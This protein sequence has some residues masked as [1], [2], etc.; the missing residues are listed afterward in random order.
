MVK[1][2][3][4][5]PKPS[6]SRAESYFCRNFISSIFSL[7]IFSIFVPNIDFYSPCLQKALSQC[8][9]DLKCAS[10]KGKG[11]RKLANNEIVDLSLLQSSCCFSCCRGEEGVWGLAIEGRSFPNLSGRSIPEVAV[12]TAFTLALW[13]TTRFYRFYNV[14]SLLL[15]NSKTLSRFLWCNHRTATLKFQCSHQH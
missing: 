13:Y 1:G 3:R 14:F 8:D 5:G 10:H 9:W 15:K 11:R 12:N 6:P 7:V 2:N 4:I